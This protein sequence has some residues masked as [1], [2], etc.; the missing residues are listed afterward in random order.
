MSGTGVWYF[1]VACYAM[2]GTDARLG[3]RCWYGEW[4]WMR[5]WEERERDGARRRLLPL[6]CGAG[7]ED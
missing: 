4:P 6:L 2:S 3:V 5:C 7:R 1:C